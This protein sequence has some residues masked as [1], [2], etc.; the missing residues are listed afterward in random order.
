MSAS[1]S[2]AASAVSSRALESSSSEDEKAVDGADEAMIEG[3]D[4]DVEAS[5]V[6]SNDV[7]WHTEAKALESIEF[8]GNPAGICD[9]FKAKS[10]FEIFTET[11]TA[12]LVTL[13]VEQSNLYARQLGGTLD[14]EPQELLA[15]LG[16]TI[17]MGV[18][19]LPR[20]AQ[21][22]GEFA[23]ELIELAFTRD[24]YMDILKY[25]HLN[26][27][28]QAIARGQIGYDP[29][30]KIR[31]LLDTLNRTFP[32]LYSPGKELTIDESMC[33]F[34]GRLFFKQY[35]KIKP[36]KWGIKLFSLN[37]SSSGFL[38]RS[39]VYTG[40]NT[41]YGDDEKKLD[42]E[43]KMISARSVLG[44]LMVS[45]ISVTRCSWTIGSVV[46]LCSE[47]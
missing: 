17:M 2:A 38:L 8:D 5:E 11:L 14:L 9:D 42:D 4:D 1:S 7:K 18:L 45:R 25:L 37:D 13:I 33:P 27:N 20:R 41:D 44:S 12:D 46:I 6:E 30:V 16:V 36:C 26:D 19:V 24:R 23:P 15:W 22:W 39:I 31:P 32:L 43:L 40:K 47:N 21:Y 35:I 10:L 29:L 28:T 3:V 34:K